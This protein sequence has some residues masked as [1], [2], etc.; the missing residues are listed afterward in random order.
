[1]FER[2]STVEGGFHA[3]APQQIAVNGALVGDAIAGTLPYRLWRADGWA[4]AL[5]QATA[6]SAATVLREATTECRTANVARILP[7]VKA[8]RRGKITKGC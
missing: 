8:N 3:Q 1:M 2:R 5:R 4:E 7:E 6:V